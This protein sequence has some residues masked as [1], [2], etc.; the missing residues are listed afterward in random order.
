VARVCSSA[1]SKSVRLGRLRRCELLDVIVI[2]AGVSGLSCARILEEAG[3]S[4]ELLEK[5]RGVGGRCHTR[6]IEGQPVDMGVAF[7]HGDN[8]VFL[9]ALDTY[10]GDVAFEWPVS[11]SGEGPTCAPRGLA[12]S[13]RRV[14]LPEGLNAFPKA[15]AAGLTIHFQTLVQSIEMA[16]GACRVMSDAGVMYEARKV[17]LAIPLEQAGDLLDTIDPSSKDVAGLR[18]L[19]RMCSSSACLAV[20]ALYPASSPDPGFDLMHP[21][22][23]SCIALVS[24]DSSKRT[25][26]AYRA[27][28]FQGRTSWSRERLEA[29]KDLWSLALLEEAGRLLGTWACRPLFIHEHRWRFARID[30]APAFRQPV[31]TEVG[32][33][34]LGVTGEGFS[35]SGGVEGAFIAG[36]DLATRLLEVL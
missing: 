9:Q 26:H 25:A 27:L 20:G 11:L 2:G 24:H 17:V 13:V 14:A 34:T 33:A 22:M 3:L 15:L 18:A 28:V 19:M 5:S 12:P 31:L 1:K 8:P 36:H 10:V 29:P 6:R 23:S 30:G 32:G 4:V 16:G 21:S 7:L 35:E